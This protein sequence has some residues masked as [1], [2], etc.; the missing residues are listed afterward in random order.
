M[1]KVSNYGEYI[2]ELDGRGDVIVFRGQANSDFV[3][4]PSGL[5]GEHIATADSQIS[6]FLISISGSFAASHIL[7][8]SS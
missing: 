3:L 8:S 6:G 1:S 2:Q 7:T 5:R 4:I